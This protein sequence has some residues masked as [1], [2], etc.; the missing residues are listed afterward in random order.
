MKKGRIERM[1]KYK[2]KMWE[3]LKKSEKQKEKRIGKM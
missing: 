1:K 2:I 3:K